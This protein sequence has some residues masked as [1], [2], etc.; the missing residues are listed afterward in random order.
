MM[1]IERA[2]NIL[3]WVTIGSMVTYTLAVLVAVSNYAQTPNQHLI[4]IAFIVLFPNLLL[5][6]LTWS[7]RKIVMSINPK[8]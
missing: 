4:L 3:Q 2:C 7:V 5:C 6:F 8:Q 1:T